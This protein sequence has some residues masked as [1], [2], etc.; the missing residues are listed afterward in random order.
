[1]LNIRYIRLRV[2][3]LLFAFAV[4]ACGGGDGEGTEGVGPSERPPASTTSATDA[5]TAPPSSRERRPATIDNLGSPV[6]ADA[7]VLI[8]TVY[9]AAV[10]GDVE[11]LLQFC[12]GCRNPDYR[13]EQRAL[14]ASDKTRAEFIRVLRT[15]GAAT[16]GYT[17]PGFAP[18]GFTS[19][20]DVQDAAYLGVATPAPT[21][22]GAPAYRGIRTSFEDPHANGTG[23]YSWEGVTRG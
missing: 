1:M 10:A 8:N 20:L 21:A 12:R 15:H 13:A 11:R 14:L 22:T 2:A 7:L 23:A 19:A 17:F 6:A 18:S 3:A 16:D 4:A 9:D 5:A